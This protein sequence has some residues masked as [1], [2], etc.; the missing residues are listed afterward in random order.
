V[1]VL[2][3]HVSNMKMVRTS[4]KMVNTKFK[5]GGLHEK[6]V[7]ATLFLILCKFALCEVL[8][9]CISGWYSRLKNVGDVKMCITGQNYIVSVIVNFKFC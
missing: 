4:M 9:I 5:M 2:T 8:M 7:V 1:A 3:L 6:H